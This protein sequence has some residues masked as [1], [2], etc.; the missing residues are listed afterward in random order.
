L[1]QIFIITK[2]NFKFMT[3]QD[4]KSLIKEVL[5]EVKSQI[6]PKAMVGNEIAAWKKTCE[7]LAKKYLLIW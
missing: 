4:L 1:I 5:S 7:V 3:K 6:D 2:G